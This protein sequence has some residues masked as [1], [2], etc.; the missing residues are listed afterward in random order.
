MRAVFLLELGDTLTHGAFD[1][2]LLPKQLK[3]AVPLDI[4]GA[5][6]VARVWLVVHRLNI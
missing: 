4:M 5:S 2:L 1:L 6:S 3:E